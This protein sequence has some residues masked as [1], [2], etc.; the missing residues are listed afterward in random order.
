MRADARDNRARIMTAADEV[1]GR[2]PGASTDD[3]ARLAG[4]RPESFI[5]V[6]D[7]REGKRQPREISARSTLREYL[8]LIEQV[9]DEVDRRLA[10][11]G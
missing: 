5:A 11:A 7:V 2:S 9:T 3:V 4:F 1:F 10:D 6:L 8:E